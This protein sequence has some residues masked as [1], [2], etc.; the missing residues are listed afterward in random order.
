MVREL[1]E[2]L[3]VLTQTV[4]L[5]LILEDLH[6]ADNCTLDI[7]SAIARRREHAKLLLL[8]TFRPADLILSA[9]PLKA[10]R[11]DLLLHH[12]SHEV[13]LERL[14]ES[15]VGEYL[16]TEFTPGDLPSGLAVIIHRHSDGNPL[17]MTAML[18]HS[19]PAGRRVEGGRALDAHHAAGT[20]RSWCAGDPQADAGDA[21][22]AHDRGGATR[23]H[24]RQ[25]RG[26][27]FHCMGR[28]HPVV[29]RPGGR[30]AAV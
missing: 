7:I 25:R 17:F 14:D 21:A 26:S 27:A 15:D 9:S 30:R 6:W 13:E 18:D 16:A 23:A 22:A 19:D 28:R 5:V 24:R 2:A 8:G 11:Q 20:G 1:C 10:L 3:E 12:L 29:R 4:P